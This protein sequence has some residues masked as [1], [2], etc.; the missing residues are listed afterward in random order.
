MNEKAYIG[1]EKS[2]RREQWHPLADFVARMVI[3]HPIAC[4]I[5]NLNRTLLKK[6]RIGIISN[7]MIWKQEVKR[8]AKDRSKRKRAIV[9]TGRRA[10]REGRSAP[11]QRRGETGQEHWLSGN[12]ASPVS[13]VFL[14]F[15]SSP[16]PLAPDAL[17]EE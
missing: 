5:S 14:P 9:R 4:N 10:T 16:F 13:S 6:P 8:W 12:S 15:A 11:C 17:P 3:Y 1:C 7:W 2:L